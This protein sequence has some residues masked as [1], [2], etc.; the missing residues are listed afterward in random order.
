[1]MRKR[2]IVQAKRVA[3]PIQERSR[4]GYS[5]ACGERPKRCAETCH[6]GSAAF[7]PIYTNGHETFKPCETQSTIPEPRPTSLR[8]QSPITNHQSP[9]TFHLS[10]FTP[11]LPS[12]HSTRKE[13][14][15]SFDRKEDTKP[16]GEQNPKPSPN[17]G[18]LIT[19]A[20]V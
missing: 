1:M 9:I 7:R 2:I 17:A 15:S 14:S 6:H 13:A 11:P 16:C 10:P 3:N 20:S 19:Q 18:P 8:H 4:A 12:A 5:D